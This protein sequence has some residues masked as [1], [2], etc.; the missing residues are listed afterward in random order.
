MLNRIVQILLSVSLVGCTLLNNGIETKVETKVE[1][2]ETD[3]EIVETNV[4][5]EQ[6][7][8]VVSQLKDEIHE[9]RHWDEN[10]FDNCLQ[11]TQEEAY[12][13][14]NISTAEG[15]TEGVIGQLKIMQVVMNRVKSPCYPNSVKEVIEQKDKS[16][17]EWKYQFCTVREGVYQKTTPN[18]NAHL[19]L[20]MLEKNENP[21]TEIIAF[22]TA[23]NGYAL[24][25]WFD[26]AYQYHNHIFYKEK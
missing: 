14:M 4:T 13:L 6:N 17:G 16:H 25:Q 11:L 9:T 3:V 24:T 12:D 5:F 20:C 18:L 22:E 7:P 19:A 10:C 21:D 8:D 2:N 1:T 23:E 26:I 15:S